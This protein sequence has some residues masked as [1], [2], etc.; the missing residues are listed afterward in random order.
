MRR[1][2][3]CSLLLVSCAE[4]TT[5]L[6]DPVC[7]DPASSGYLDRAALEERSWLYRRTVVKGEVP[8][9]GS[10]ELAQ[11]RL[12]RSGD[13]LSAVRENSS[14]VLAS[15]TVSKR[16]NLTC[17]NGSFIEARADDGSYS[18]VDWGSRQGPTSF[19]PLFANYDLS[20]ENEEELA[21]WRILGSNY[22]ELTERGQLS[23]PISAC[24]KFSADFAA[25][26]NCGGEVE[27]RHALLAVGETTEAVEMRYGLSPEFSQEIAVESIAEDFRQVFP[28]FRIEQNNCRPEVLAT[29]VARHPELAPLFAS[30]P[31]SLS[32]EALYAACN[33]LEQRAPDIF[34]WQRPGSLRSR[35]IVWVEPSQSLGWGTFASRAMLP[36]G[37]IFAADLYVDG[38]RLEKWASQAL[39]VAAS[40]DPRSA[41]LISLA[42]ARAAKLQAMHFRV[43]D[44][45]RDRWGAVAHTVPNTEA[46]LAKFSLVEGTVAEELARDNTLP[47]MLLGP[48]Y[49]PGDPV[50]EVLRSMSTPRERAEYGLAKDRREN[51]ADLLLLGY[52]FLDLL[53]PTGFESL[54]LQLLTVPREERHAR[55]FLGLGAHLVTRGLAE[56]L[57][58]EPNGSGSFEKSS[59]LDI[60]HGDRMFEVTRLGPADIAQLK[61]RYFGVS[62]TEPFENCSVHD[63]L[64]QPSVSCALYDFGSTGQEIFAD[65]YWRWLGNYHFNHLIE[66]P[67]TF[68]AAE[69]FRPALDILEFGSIA[70]ALLGFHTANTADFDGSPLEQELFDVV[71]QTANF[72]T[73]VSS[74]PQAGRSCPWPGADPLIYVPGSYVRC[75]PELDFGSP[76]AIAQQIMEIPEGVGRDSILARELNEGPWQ[77]IG[78]EV[79]RLNA[80]W[81][82]NFNFP[83]SL[84]D[85]APRLTVEA[86]IGF[87]Q[88]MFAGILEDDPLAPSTDSIARRGGFW[89]RDRGDERPD[90]GHFEPRRAID[91]DGLLAPGASDSCSRPS[92]VYPSLT[93]GVYEASLVGWFLSSDE[94]L[95]IYEL[96]VDDQ[97]IDWSSYDPSMVCEARTMD[98]HNYRAVRANSGIECHLLVTLDEARN[99]VESSNQE[100]FRSHY[101]W[102]K[103]IVEGARALA[104]VYR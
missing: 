9:L 59:I 6:I 50:P 44:A 41:G 15:W 58:V 32:G 47:A 17:S 10:N 27:V 77:R 69:A 49:Q 75:D 64:L 72:V 80:I 57:G 20:F 74:V 39:E 37:D 97:E 70:A 8:F 13:R 67:E 4:T 23:A 5:D 94:P 92:P 35:T 61:F 104:G 42:Q 2:L 99:L 46:Q 86:A 95:E 43:T 79:D 51:V 7:G 65:K 88:E 96:G 103:S 63:A 19:A 54:A 83:T 66:D 18:V 78:V 24:A 62:I 31:E 45:L 100:P 55:L 76:E 85:N 48:A 87:S 3:L 36:G 26:E 52:G 90:V 22:L 68:R 16:V 98:G 25:P 40:T 89:C 30:S 28:E 21:D 1:A 11:V 101:L 53:A 60:Y 38:A 102:R 73:E 91:L 81:A 29:A 71:A 82:V 56:T 93:R 14:E 84:A 34:T 33:A 12:T